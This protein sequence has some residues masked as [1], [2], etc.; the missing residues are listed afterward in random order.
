MN[1]IKTSKDLASA[2]LKNLEELAKKNKNHEVF[3]M[4]EKWKSIIGN[5]KLADNCEL[6]DIKNNTLIIK[7]NHTGWSQQITP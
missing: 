3:P 1:N 5:K 6:Q 7:T 4:Y 2:F